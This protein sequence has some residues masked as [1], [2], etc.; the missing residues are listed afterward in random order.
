MPIIREE[1]SRLGIAPVCVRQRRIEREVCLDALFSG[2][3]LPNAHRSSRL[4]TSAA[5]SREVSSRIMRDKTR[6]ER[7]P[8]ER[9]SATLN[10]LLGALNC[11]GTRQARIRNSQLLLTLLSRFPEMED[12]WRERDKHN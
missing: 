11:R 8:P 3:N 7:K 6:Q 12:G 9:A 4:C 5:R 2:G 1:T 10:S